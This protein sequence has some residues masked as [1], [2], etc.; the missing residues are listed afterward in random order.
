MSYVPVLGRVLNAGRGDLASGHKLY[1]KHCGACHT[2][3]GE[4]TKIGPDLTVADRKNRDALL[5]NILDPS[6]TIR[7]EF[8]S[9]TAVLVDGRVITGLVIES[10]EKQLTIVDSKQ[11]KTPIERDQVEQ[12]QPSDTSIMPERLL[13]TLSEQEVRDLFAY[14]QS[15]EAKVRSARKE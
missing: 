6:G 2:L 13:E 1:M 8:V 5:L 15:D 12:L 3:H 10:N 9:Q 4:G 7:P 14:L 11:Q